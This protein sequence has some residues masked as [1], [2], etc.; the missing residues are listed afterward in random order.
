VEIVVGAKHLP[1]LDVL[2]GPSELLAH[3]PA[4]LVQQTGVFAVVP[5][6]VGQRN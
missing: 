3:D 4:D 6:P 2:V 5:Y 1:E